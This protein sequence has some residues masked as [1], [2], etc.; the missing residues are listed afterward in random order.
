MTF[1]FPEGAP[2]N[3]QPWIITFGPRDSSEDW[4]PVVCGPYERAHAL[5]L[6]QNLLSDTDIMGVVEPLLPATTLDEIRAQIVLSMQYSA[7]SGHEE[8]DDELDS[9]GELNGIAE[10]HAEDHADD[11]DDEDHSIAQEP[12]PDE[13]R[14]GFAR[15]SERLTGSPGLTSGG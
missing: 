12:T 14:A 11:D 7:A 9:D 3:D 15:I 8:D 1:E 4:E 5:A 13:I 2:Q 10:D 6:A